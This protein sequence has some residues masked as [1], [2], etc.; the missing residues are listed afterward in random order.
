[1]RVA[2]LGPTGTFTEE[3]L[4]ASAPGDVEELA[5]PTV[6]E[7][8]MAVQS[9]D[10]DRAIV[11]IENSIE[12]SVTATLDALAGEAADV[13][14]VEEVVHPISHSLIAARVIDL[15]E[16]TCVV[17]H[18]QAMS[19]CARYLRERVPQAARQSAG[20]TADAVRAVADS[21]E[22][23]AA[24]G[25]ELAAE[26]YGCEVLETGVEDHPDNRTR[27]VWLAREG[28]A[29]SASASKTSVVFWGFND[30]SPGALVAVLGE[31]AD[32]DVNLTK[33]ESRPRR[34]QLGHYMF[35]ADLDGA[36]TGA[37]VS[38]ALDGLRKR[39]EELRVL[40]SYPVRHA[41]GGR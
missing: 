31:F 30:D 2:F 7:T 19:Q 18:A 29:D 39:V 21:D 27:F 25:S 37:P 11:P 17:S 41:E 38:E 16:I 6:Y 10:A 36:D 40:G 4:R 20:S 13:R 8:V 15:G 26:L 1:M 33:I 24:L 5:Y 14:I 35:F 34:G 23:W 32:R 3:A 9:G 12:G 28:D 22:P